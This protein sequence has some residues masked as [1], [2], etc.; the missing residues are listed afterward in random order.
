MR[1]TGVILAA[2]I[3]AGCAN[4]DQSKVSDW[5]S[6]GGAM[7]RGAGQGD[8]AQRADAIRQALQLG[9]QRATAELSKEGA[10][11]PGTRY[12]IPL[13][14]ELQTVA[15]M[16]RTAG[17]GER[18]DQLE[19]RMNRGAEEAVG[20]AAP[21]FRQAIREMTVEDALA[22]VNGD[23]GSATRY[24]RQKSTV[25]LR[26]RFRPLIRENLEQTGFYSQYRGLL[27]IYDTLPMTDKPDLDIETRVLDHTLDAVF[28]RLAAE[29]RAIREA[30]LE[31]GSELIRSVF[32]AGRG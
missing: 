2:L 27:D 24:F 29:E 28:H 20:E 6:F 17:Y 14:E 13:P 9:S 16:L 7:A 5:L 26:E 10:F 12:H 8:E 31:R 3:L 32:G 23:P 15:G 1:A 4:M 30:P 19:Q 11:D 25:A 22:I 18:I 21:V